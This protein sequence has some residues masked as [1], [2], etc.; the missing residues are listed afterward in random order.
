MVELHYLEADST[1]N[2]GT[3]R[4]GHTLLPQYQN[5]QSDTGTGTGVV[6]P[7]STCD[8]KYVYDEVK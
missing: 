8:W 2:F 7:P 3:P 1:N 5:P 4:E 6:K